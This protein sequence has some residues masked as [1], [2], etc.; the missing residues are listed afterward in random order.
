[1]IASSLQTEVRTRVAR[2]SKPEAA[3]SPQR[4]G[5]AAAAVRARLV[6][7]EADLRNARQRLDKANAARAEADRARTASPA[8]E[9]LREQAR[10]ARLA[11]EDAEADVAAFEGNLEAMRERQADPRMLGLCREH[12]ELEP[13]IAPAAV[14]PRR[15]VLLARSR[16]IAELV[17]ALLDD[18][19]EFSADVG[20]VSNRLSTIA[21]ELGVDIGRSSAVDYGL[22]RGQLAQALA[23][24]CTAKGV[25]R[26]ELLRLVDP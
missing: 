12:A 14:E 1:M 5:T 11:V 2:A 19:R 8:N 16:K 9:I 15:Q 17:A 6:N 26:E 23:G 24:A 18:A 3:P 22:L 20:A 4:E 13:K 21:S 7:A 25:T 10:Q